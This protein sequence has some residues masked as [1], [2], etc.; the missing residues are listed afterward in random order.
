MKVQSLDDLFVSELRDLYSVEKQLAKSLPRMARAATLGDLREAFRKHLDETQTHIQRLERI[1]DQLQVRPAGRRCTAMVGMINEVKDILS[2]A[3][4]GPTLDAGLIGAA[5]KVEHY[6]IAGYGTVRTYAQTL[7]RAE[8]AN[9]LQQTL[10]EEAATDKKLTS[11]AEGVV[12]SRATQAAPAGT[13][14]S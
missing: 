8:M 4:P 6:E 9:L 13:T 3:T 12:N 11:L 2:M 5:Q 14:R 10:D 1:F 7:G